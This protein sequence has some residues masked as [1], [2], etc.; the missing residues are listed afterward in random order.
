MATV[1]SHLPQSQSPLL[2][3]LQYVANKP[4]AAFYTPGHKQGRGASSALVTLLGDGVFTADLPELPGLDNLFNPDG[5]IQAAQTLAAQ[6]F[7]AS[8]SWFLAN[9]STCGIEAAVLATCSPG[10]SIIVPR[11]AHQSVVSALILSGASPIFVA[12]EVDEAWGIAHGISAVAVEQALKAYPDT[13]AVLIVSPTYYGVCC[14]VEAIARLAHSFDVPL[15]VDEA[16]GAHFTFHPDLPPSALAQGADLTV[17]STHKVLSALTQASMLHIQG[18]CL[19]PSRISRVLQ[20]LQSSSPSYLLLAS[21]DAA[22]A[23]M[24]EDGLQLMGRTLDLANHA[25]RAIAQIPGLQVLEL[26]APTPAAAHLDPTRVTVDVSGLRITGFEADEIFH[27]EL[28]VTAELP[29][30]RTLTFIVSLGNGKEDIEQLIRAFQTLAQRHYS[31]DKTVDADQV[32]ADRGRIPAL[33]NLTGVSVPDLSPR[34]AFFAK[35]E[36]VAIAQA[37]GRVSNETICLYP[38]GI[39]TVLP[40][41]KI[42]AEAIQMLQAIQEAGGIITGC[43]DSSLETVRVIAD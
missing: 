43:A 16:H 27:E 25:R 2:D 7:G 5:V 32:D 11:N 39:P 13:K 28:G 33:V 19:D 6:S 35:S 42:T 8:Q 15:L 41:E 20:L 10:D 31:L 4:H 17:Q 12:P 24:D 34:D 40:G 30:L 14:H 3:S 37:I 36:V 1:P 22:R 9:G 23:Q 38:P 21:L 18:N 26:P 29:G